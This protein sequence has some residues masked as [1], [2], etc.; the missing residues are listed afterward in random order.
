MWAKPTES[1][2]YLTGL[3]REACAPE[4]YTTIQRAAETFLG[5]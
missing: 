3:Y 5:G 4:Y 1:T 2:E